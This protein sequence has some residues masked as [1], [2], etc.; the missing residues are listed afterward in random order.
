[1]PNYQKLIE[2]IQR[3]QQEVSVI[4]PELDERVLDVAKRYIVAHHPT[5][6]G[7]G[8]PTISD[9][10]FTW[11]IESGF[12]HVE[13]DE[14]WN[15]GGHDQGAFSFPVKYIWDDTAL[16]AYEKLRAEAKESKQKEANKCERETELKQLQILQEKYPETKDE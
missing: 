14:F 8:Y 6:R 10:D 16:V 9:T 3:L 2:Q 1:M 13:W 7:Y 15:Y 11:D 12:V 4:R 5:N